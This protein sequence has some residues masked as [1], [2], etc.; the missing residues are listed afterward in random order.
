MRVILFFYVVFVVEMLFVRLRVRMMRGEG[1][2]K[3]GHNSICCYTII[4]R[5]E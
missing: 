1:S 2:V 3:G 4:E 5:T